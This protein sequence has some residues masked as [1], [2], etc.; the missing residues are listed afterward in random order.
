MS[1]ERCDARVFT[2]G[3]TIAVI[4]DEDGAAIE[5]WVKLLA[6]MSRARADWYW[7][8][9]RAIVKTLGNPERVN[10]WAH[11]LAFRL[12]CALWWWFW[13]TRGDRQ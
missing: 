10:K 9:G 2:R 6:S 3:I 8:G 7:L 1:R 12:P 5:R 11:K 4:A 13:E